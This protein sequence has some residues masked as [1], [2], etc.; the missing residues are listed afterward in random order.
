MKK[1][2]ILTLASVFALSGLMTGCF[3]D[4]TSS[5][6]APT[7]NEFESA[8]FDESKDT[9]AISTK[10]DFY[11]KVSDE[12]GLKSWTLQVLDASG[13]VVS[14]ATVPTISG[15]S[16]SFDLPSK[17]SVNLSITNDGTW[18]ATG[19]YSVVLTVTNT[20]GNSIKSTQTIIAKGNGTTNPTTI[21]DTTVTLGS[22]NNAN[23]GSLDADE[24]RTY[25]I[26]EVTS[27]AI[28]GEIDLYYGFS[29]ATSKDR[30]FTPAQAKT[31]GFNGIKDWTNI[32]AIEIY[33]LGTMTESAFDAIDT[34][35]EI[36]AAF[37]GKTAESDGSVDAATGVVIGLKT[38]DDLMTL[39]RCTNITTGAAGTV[40]IKG[41]F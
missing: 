34:E 41:K 26:S 18:G 3:E 10:I 27:T 40:Q 2:R 20:Q 36:E 11:G 12:E 35:A 37:T 24:M 28:Q 15:T 17:S 38:S 23:G 8:N 16:T 14:T 13:K 9:L 39:I 21:G 31:S 32:A 6:S 19:K 22:N 29:A 7:I 4:A 33:D 1:F 30:F 5:S 25:K